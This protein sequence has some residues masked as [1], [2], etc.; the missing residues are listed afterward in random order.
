[1]IDHIDAATYVGQVEMDP[2][3]ALWAVLYHGDTVLTREQVRSLRKGKRRVA[4]LVLSAA[5]AFPAGLRRPAPTH[6]NRIVT[7]PARPRRR[8]VNVAAV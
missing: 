2:A 8:Q 7:Q 5:D 1:M 3:G 4:D 6:L